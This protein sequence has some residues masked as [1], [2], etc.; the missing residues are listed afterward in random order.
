M[1]RP[2]L[3]NENYGSFIVVRCIFIDAKMSP[4]GVI[5]QTCRHHNLAKSAKIGYGAKCIE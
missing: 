5:L 3:S 1:T 4:V 2:S